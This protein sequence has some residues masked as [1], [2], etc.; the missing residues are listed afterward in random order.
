M[1]T[2]VTRAM[3]GNT[4][5]PQ[6]TP[7]ATSSESGMDFL[8]LSASWLHEVLTDQ[9]DRSPPSQLELATKLCIRSRSSSPIPTALA[10]DSWAGVIVRRPDQGPKGRVEGPCFN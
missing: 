1:P 10:I 7:N 4:M 2:T 5:E 3:A 6:L 9:I 8:T